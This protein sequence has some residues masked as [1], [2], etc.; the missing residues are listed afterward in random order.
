MA[1]DIDDSGLTEN[2]NDLNENVSNLNQTLESFAKTFSQSRVQDERKGSNADWRS[3][4]RSPKSTSRSA[5]D[6][7]S[8]ALVDALG[9][10]DVKTSLQKSMAGLAED[11]GVEFEDLPG[12]LSETLTKGLLDGFKQSKFGSS[13]ADRLKKS[14]DKWMGK[15]EGYFKEAG[16]ILKTAKLGEAG[17][18]AKAAATVGVNLAKGAVSSAISAAGGPAGIALTL[19]TTALAPMA[20]AAMKFFKGLSA[21]ANRDSA[22]RKKMEEEG[23]K[24]LRSVIESIVK[25]P[26]E[27]LQKAAQAMYDAWDSNLR[28]INQTQGYSIEEL[29][30]LIGDF[31]TRIR[32]EGLESVVS[33]SDL[34]NNLGNVLK[35]GLAGEIAEEFAYIA[36]KLNAAIPTEDFFQYS[37]TY[38]ALIANAIKDGKSQS[39]AIGYA[40]EQLE[41][42][43]SNVLYAS[44]QIT[45]GISTGLKSSSDLFQ[46]AVQISMAARSGNVSNIAGTITSISA[47]TGA[48]APD[49]ASSIIDA[50]YNAAVGGNSSQIVALRSLAGINASNTEFLQQFASNPQKVFSDL[51]NKLSQMQNMS[52]SNYM[53]VAEGLSKVFGLDM[54][55]FARVDF[56]YLAKAIDNM[57]VSSSSLDEN[58]KQLASGE[59]T[60]TAEQ[61]K[62]RQINEYMMNEGLAYVLD[63][64]VARSIQEHM[65][66]EQTAI[67][68]QEATYAVELK[69]AANEALNLIKDAGENIINILTLGGYKASRL[70]QTV[71]EMNGLE[72]KVKEVLEAGKI[73]SGDNNIISKLTTYGKKLDLTNSYVSMLKQ[74]ASVGS[75]GYSWSNLGKSTY[76]SLGATP[77]GREAISKILSGTNASKEINLAKMQNNLNRMLDTMSDFFGDTLNDTFEQTLAKETDKLARNKMSQV[78]EAS[79]LARTAE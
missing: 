38:A 32:K 22:T 48:I 53:E 3:V 74:T 19:I 76:A 67:E 45:G 27:T 43:A 5:M 70:H 71:E 28:I 24:R 47:I 58:M 20:E 62:I 17:L 57:T 21:A 72:E 66:Q 14:Q 51:F 26:F 78:T 39:E 65:W 1:F 64:E 52:T 36:T 35:S 69:G 60:L 29:Q 61:L 23:N 54:A 73:G 56:S 2:I 9:L 75:V 10:D 59:S 42:F 30:T 41:Q 4:G 34:T 68:I 33:A 55:S 50:V 25:A 13:V 8:K 44:R 15:S 6:G 11:L 77:S 37:D 12:T 7:V 18:G 63:N 79:I 16:N 40:N 31:A 46:K 49:L